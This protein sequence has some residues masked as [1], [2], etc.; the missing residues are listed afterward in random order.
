MSIRFFLCAVVL[1]GVAPAQLLV[2][3]VS[4]DE[5][6]KALVRQAREYMQQMR[7]TTDYG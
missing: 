2:P 3:R 7:E 5:A 4:T 1:S 6:G